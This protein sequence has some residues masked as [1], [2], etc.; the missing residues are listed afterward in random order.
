MTKRERLQACINGQE[1]DRPPIS[2]WHH[3]PELDNNPYK[4]AQAIIQF[5][6][7]YDLDFI[8]L[9]PNGLYS[10]FDWGVKIKPHEKNARTA[11]ASCHAIHEPTDWELLEP[12]NPTEGVLGNQLECIKILAEQLKGEVPMLQTIFSP[13]TTASKM[14]GN[15]VLLDHLQNYPEQLHAGLEV[16]T[17]TSIDFTHH[18][19]ELGVDGIFFAT[20]WASYTPLSEEKY[21]EFG[22]AYDM[23]ILNTTEDNTSFNI[24][25]IHGEEIMFDLLVD[26]PVQA[27]NWHDRRT[28]P[29]LGEAVAKYGG[30]VVGGLDHEETMTHGTTAQITQQVLDAIKQTRGKRLIIGPGCVLNP[31]VQDWRL[32]AARAAIDMPQT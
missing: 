7:R 11:E 6:N 14:A 4:L 21:H 2:L 25:H 27:I 9:M 15:E 5:Q 8:K 12:L 29:T 30:C 18:C 32:H 22:K 13:L 26:Y 28:R 20:K 16:I 31:N 19:I 24:L 10:V 17:Q 1:V 23:R 3:F